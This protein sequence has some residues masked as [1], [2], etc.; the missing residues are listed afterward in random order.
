MKTKLIMNPASGSETAI[1]HLPMMNERLRGRGGALDIVITMTEGDAARAGREAVLDGYDRLFVA[2]GDGTLNEVLNGVAGVDGGLAAVTFGVI[3]LGT[4]NDF[5]TALG[6]PE[7]PEAALGAL[8]DGE[9]AAVDVGRMNDRYFL[10]ISAGGFIAEVS[11][12]VNPQL[13]TV[14][15]K[16]AY[17][18]GG[19]QVLLGYDPVGTHVTPGSAG[20]GGTRAVGPGATAPAL[21]AELGLYAFAVCNSRLIGGGR[22]IAPYAVVDDGWLDVCLIE[23]MPT[24]DFLTLLR[25]VSG[26][27]H[28]EDERVTYFQARELELTFDRPI[29]VNTDGEVLE[30]GR[31]TFRV[32]PGAARVLMPKAGA[33]T[34]DDE[35]TESFSVPLRRADPAPAGPPRPE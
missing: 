35:D 23:A 33:G 25:R 4:G 18:V 10:N 1:D 24:I 2:G 21:P 17:L 3:P 6:L 20:P 34:R 14:M 7:D 26:G 19:A 12:A 29:K 31:C 30:A 32:L 28:V 16:L 22:L 11:E 27:D 13:K 15:G 8:L 5:A 9:P